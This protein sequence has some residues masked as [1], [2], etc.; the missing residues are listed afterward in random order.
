MMKRFVF[1]LLAAVLLAGCGLW[2]RGA[3]SDETPVSSLPAEAVLT[4]AAVIKEETAAL[5]RGSQ[6]TLWAEQFIFSDPELRDLLI[7]RAQAGV[8]VHIL[9]D[10]WQAANQPTVEILKNNN[11]SVQYY[12]AQR[13]QYQ[14]VRYMVADGTAALLYSSDWAAGAARRMAV[15]LDGG[16]AARLAR[17]F[18]ADWQYTTTLSL[19]S[20]VSSAADDSQV[21]MSE[22]AALRLEVLRRIDGA[23][24][25]ILVES[26]Q[27]SQ[28]DTLNALI[29]ARERGCVVRALLNP[30]VVTATPNSLERLLAAGVEVRLY[31]GGG[32]E[33]PEIMDYTFA[34]F[35]EKTLLFAASAWSHATFVINHETLATIPAPACAEKMRSLFALD[36]ENAASLQS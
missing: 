13:G 20:P 6:T 25:E 29:A 15:R 21:T 1:F 2:P 17:G 36:W 23:S 10:R 11:V 8:D 9:L 16:A 19:S 35:D 7:E 28:E 34:V 18:A 27:I 30:D 12:P 4:D 32:E 14:R 31:Q 33:T 24:R 26:I 22:G 3:Q 5:I